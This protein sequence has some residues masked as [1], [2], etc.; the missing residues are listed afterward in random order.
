MKN[1]LLLLLI[2]C[3]LI[4]GC[5]S[6]ELVDPT[7]SIHY[8]ISERSHVKMFV[9]N[10]YDVLIITLVDEV[11]PEGNHSVSFQ[12]NDLANGIYYF[13][14]ETTGV[15][16]GKKSKTTKTFILSK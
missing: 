9:T 15:S 13:T 1:K 6:S 10:T 16:S 3:F 12:M 14:I 4:F 8:N 7:T 2:F 11:L 5:E